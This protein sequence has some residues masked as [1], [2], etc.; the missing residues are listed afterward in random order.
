M[1]VTLLAT[2]LTVG[3]VV[4]P[5][6]AAGADGSP[7][8]PSAITSTQYPKDTPTKPSG[9]SAVTNVS[10]FYRI[11]GVAPGAYT[12]RA[13]HGGECGLASVYDNVEVTGDLYLDFMLLPTC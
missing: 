3:W 11:T 8:P 13:T 10:G 7:A 12:L 2:A 1:L 4:A 9:Q 5:Q 6:P